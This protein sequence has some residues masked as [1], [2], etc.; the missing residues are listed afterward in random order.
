MR[1]KGKVY[2]RG[3]F[4]D[5]RKV[6]AMRVLIWHEDTELQI[7]WQTAFG[8]RGHDVRRAR[9]ADEAMLLVRHNRFDLIVFDM[10]VG[11]ESGLGVAL[12]AEFHQPECAT[13]LVSDY[14]PDF[15]MDLFSRLSSLRSLLST[16]ISPADLVAI[17]ES[18]VEGKTCYD[19]RRERPEICA[20]CS[21]QSACD[22]VDD[23]FNRPEPVFEPAPEPETTPEP[24]P[25][26]AENV[27]VLD[28]A[29]HV[30]TTNAATTNAAATA[31][32]L[33]R[34]TQQ[35][36]VEQ[37][38][39]EQDLAARDVTDRQSHEARLSSAAQVQPRKRFSRA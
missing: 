24:A 21:V 34:L 25:N 9:D 5:V 30:T 10:L 36:L 31:S 18:A 38:L 17:S 12:L 13:I 2:Q 4:A 8:M 39:G 33:L 23:A 27:T 26:A 14:S 37:G 29:T 6:E 32:H 20:D 11:Q 7:R 28:T 19:I 16:T 1:P 3:T 35:D 22:V 15:Q